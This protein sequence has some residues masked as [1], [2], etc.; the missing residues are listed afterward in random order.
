MLLDEALKGAHN[1]GADIDKVVLNELDISP[2]QECQRCFKT[3][4][5]AV[6]DDFQMVYKNIQSAEG[7]II[8]SPIFFT[9]VTAQLKT[10]IDRFQCVWAQ[11]YI[12]K[13][14]DN[15][16]RRGKR[17]VFLSVSALSQPGFFECASNVIKAFFLM[18]G[19]G[20]EG[21]LF[22]QGIDEKGKIGEYQDYLKKAY[23]LGEQVV[24]YTNKH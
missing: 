1:K 19:A 7:I 2:C 18:I 20:Y 17:G 24:L 3:G 22:C 13:K 4:Y 23:E 15:W 8:A 21:E 5:C 10:T 9:T 16:N 14:G 12:L 11:K 6:N